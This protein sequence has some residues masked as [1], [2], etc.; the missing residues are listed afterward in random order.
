MLTKSRS[1]VDMPCALLVRFVCFDH[2]LLCSLFSVPYVSDLCNTLQQKCI[3]IHLAMITLSL[4][5]YS[6]I[7]IRPVLSGTIV[8][9]AVIMNGACFLTIP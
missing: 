4:L 7:I 9:R 6:F 3:S 8:W 1:E 2:A 5:V